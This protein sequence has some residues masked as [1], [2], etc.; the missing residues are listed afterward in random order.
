VQSV[1][2]VLS[3]ERYKVVPKEV[4]DYTKGL[5]GRPPAPIKDTIQKK[6]LGNEKP[7]DTRPADLLEPIMKKV[8]TEVPKELILKEED[9]ISYALFPEVSLKFFNW[10]KNPESRPQE[11]V[12]FQNSGKEVIVN[13]VDGVQ[14]VKELIEL[15]SKNNLAELEW[16]YGGNRIKIRRQ[17]T[18][19][20]EVLPE[21]RVQEVKIAEK[22]AS[23][24]TKPEIAKKVET[25]AKKYEEIKSPMVGTYYGRSRPDAP[26]FVEKG[27]AVE[28]GQTL[29]IIEAMK[30]MNEIDAEKKCK[31][32]EILVE[33]GESVE[34]GEPLFLIEPV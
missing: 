12:D 23:V 8:K 31:I 5:Y 16:D 25:E 33:D 19:V 13:G 29:C 4:K 20:A 3:G 28:P 10:R 24:E 21:P 17:G 9:Y 34:Y 6:I 2:N 32:M 7:I 14:V 11:V 26:P 18:I 15:A 22:S 27:D 30:L 1:F